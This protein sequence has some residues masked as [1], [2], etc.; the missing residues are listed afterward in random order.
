MTRI[1]RIL[2]N[3]GYC[4]RARVRSFLGEHDVRSAGT[5]LT[6]GDVRVD[7]N[8]I[9]VDGQPLDPPTL[10]LLMHKPLGLVCSHDEREGKLPTGGSPTAGLVY[11]LLPER[12]RRRDPAIAT[13]GR[14]DKE[15]TGTLLLTDDG[16]ILHRLTSPKHHKPRTYLVTLDR[17]LNGQ[18]P[19]LFASGTLTLQADTKPLLPAEMQPISP[20]QARLTLHEG[21]YHQV[22]RMFAATGNHVTALHRESFGPFNVN[23]LPLGTWRPLTDDELKTL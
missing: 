11:D 14:L 2:A 12:Y 15:T 10:I 18:E 19:A 7:E 17:D 16:Q 8:A 22:R 20:R 3:R 9:T 5:R 4:A 23:N 13:V 6:R 1:E 21:R